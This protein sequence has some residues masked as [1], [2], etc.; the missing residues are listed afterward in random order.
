MVAVQV[1][2]ESRA[3]RD[4]PAFVIFGVGEWSKLHWLSVLVE[5]AK[6]RQFR[7]TVVDISTETPTELRD[8]RFVIDNL[9][10]KVIT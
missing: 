2:Q 1:E 7:L 8:F 10:T 6:K 5:F 9:P 4:I 3:R